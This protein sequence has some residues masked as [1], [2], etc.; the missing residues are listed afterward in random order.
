MTSQRSDSSNRGFASMDKEKQREVSAKGGRA[1]HEASNVKQQAGE[2]TRSDNARQTTKAGR[3][4]HK[5]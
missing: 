1:S 2:G 3:Q 5:S 4:A